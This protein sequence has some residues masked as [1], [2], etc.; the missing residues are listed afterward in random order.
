MEDHD[1]IRIYYSGA[2]SCICIGDVN[3]SEVMQFCTIG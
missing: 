3:L 1:E 2:D